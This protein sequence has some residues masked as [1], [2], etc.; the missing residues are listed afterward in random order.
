[1]T[2][3][4]GA[5]ARMAVD[6]VA[7][8]EVMPVCARL[9]E[10]LFQALAAVMFEL[11]RPVADDL[12]RRDVFDPLAGPP[13]QRVNEVRGAKQAAQVF[14]AALVTWKPWVGVEQPKQAAKCCLIDAVLCCQV[15]QLL[16]LR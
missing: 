15:Q 5:G 1:M 2:N 7:H 6:A 11:P 4:D 10:E 9:A 16:E 3:P 8:Q 14:E 12:P 13:V